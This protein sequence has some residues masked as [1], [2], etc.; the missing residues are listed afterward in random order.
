MSHP[1][2]IKFN[3]SLAEFAERNWKLK[4]LLAEIGDYEKQNENI[5]KLIDKELGVKEWITYPVFTNEDTASNLNP[6]GWGI[7]DKDGRVVSGHYASTKG[8]GNTSK[9]LYERLHPEQS[10]YRVVQLFYKDEET[11]A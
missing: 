10:P 5:R 7:V 8:F 11:K 1:N 4:K 2:R 9:A 3:S 6:Y